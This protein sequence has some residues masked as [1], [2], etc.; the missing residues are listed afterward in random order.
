MKKQILFCSF[1][2]KYTLNKNC[3]ICEKETIAPKP[4]KFSL[5]DKYGEYRREVKRKE[6]IKKGLY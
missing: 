4:P 2:L 5:Q 3:P 6:L 1:C